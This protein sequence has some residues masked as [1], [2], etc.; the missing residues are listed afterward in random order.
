M[1]GHQ[2]SP[3]TAAALCVKPHG[4]MT[5]R[6]AVNVD[7]LEAASA[8]FTT[9]RQLAMRFRG[10][11]RGGTI[12]KLD[13]WLGDARQCGIFGMRRF[14]RTLRQDIGAVRNAGDDELLTSGG[15]DR[16]TEIRV[17]PRVHGRAVVDGD[18]GKRPVT[19]GMKGPEN[20][21]AA[22]VEITVGVLK[23]LADFANT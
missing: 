22:I 10:L 19:S 5:D 2:T 6:Q 18:L 13:V 8:E 1:T 16:V 20:E 23:S 11:L 7:V 14:A 9:M 21:A 12:G 4:Q 17:E 15:M 3:L